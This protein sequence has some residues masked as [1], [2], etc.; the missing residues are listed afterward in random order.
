[1]PALIGI[2]VVLGLLGLAYLTLNVV[3][4][5]AALGLESVLMRLGIDDP[6]LGWSLFGTT[7]GAVIGL[8]IQGRQYRIRWLQGLATWLFI[9]MV[10]MIGV[11]YGWYGAGSRVPRPLPQSQVP[12]PART[13]VVNGTSV[14]LRAQPSTDAQVLSRL[15]RGQTATLLGA[16]AG[17]LRIRAESSGLE[18]WVDSRY[19]EEQ[20]RSVK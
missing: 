20:S 1:M 8:G 11:G 4:L 3:G 7:I 15:N 17:W 16:E 5:M 19:V 13:V 12:Q 2:G 9:G 18:G 10:V 6:V 14:N